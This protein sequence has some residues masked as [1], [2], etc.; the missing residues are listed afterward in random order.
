MG[1]LGA[2]SFKLAPQMAV[3]RPRGFWRAGLCRAQRDLR[4]R[5]ERRAAAGKEGAQM[6]SILASTPAH[7]ALLVVGLLQMQLGSSAETPWQMSLGSRT[8]PRSS[9]RVASRTRRCNGRQTAGAV[10]TL[11]EPCWHR[12]A[13]GLAALCKQLA[14]VE[15]V[16]AEVEPKQMSNTRRGAGG[17]GG[18]GGLGACPY[19]RWL[20]YVFG[21]LLVSIPFTNAR[22]TLHKCPWKIPN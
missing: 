18:G 1:W 22:L 3:L 8:S 15:K 19:F 12:A 13:R 5:V 21:H 16:E 4:G 7:W 14:E 6:V 17:G 9:L 2:H 11:P 20:Y 10:A